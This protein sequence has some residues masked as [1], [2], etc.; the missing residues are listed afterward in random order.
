MSP[1]PL[2]ISL[3]LRKW[4]WFSLAPFTQG[5]ILIQIL[6]QIGYCVYTDSNPDSDHISKVD[7]PD[8]DPDSG[9]G[10][11]VNGAFEQLQIFALLTQ[12]L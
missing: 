7:D 5:N 1:D 3:I 9:P 11:R 12:Q 6:I 2:Y 8:S 4:V 10:A